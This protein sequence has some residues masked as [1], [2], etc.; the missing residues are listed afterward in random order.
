MSFK[1]NAISDTQY[2]GKQASQPKILLLLPQCRVKID[3]GDDEF[4]FLFVVLISLDC[5]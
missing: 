1:Q 5:L 4:P 3:A 2:M